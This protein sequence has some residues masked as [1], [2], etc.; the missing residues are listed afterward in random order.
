[1][2]EPVLASSPRRAPGAGLGPPAAGAAGLG[3]A[4]PPAARLG[5]GTAAASE[6]HPPERGGGPTVKKNTQKNQKAPPNPKRT[7]KTTE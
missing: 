2:A 6:R 1:M 3:A 5:A 7:G 4:S